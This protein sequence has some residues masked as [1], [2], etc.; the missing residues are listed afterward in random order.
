MK[1]L[2]KLL[3]AYLV[4]F[5]LITSAPLQG[6]VGLELPEWFS[7]EADAIDSGDF[8]YTVLSDGTAQITA[9]RGGESEVV[10]PETIDGIKVTEIG[11]NLF[12]NN[13][14]L[15]SI[16]LPSG[17]R[18]LGEGSFYNTSNLKE[19]YF[20]GDVASWCSMAIYPDSASPFVYGGGKLYIDGQFVENLVVPEGVT[21][22]GSR[23]F[24][25]YDHLKSVDFPSTLKSIEAFAFLHCDGLETL[26]IPDGVTTLGYGA[27]ELCGALKTVILG[28]GI[29]TIDSDVFY[30]SPSISNVYYSGVESQ[31]NKISFG[32]YNTTLTNAKRHYNYDIDSHTLDIPNDAISYDGN[33]YKAFEESLDW[34]EAKARCEEMGGHLMTVT[35]SEEQNIIADLLNNSPRDNYWLGATDT[36]VEG[37]WKWITGEPFEYTNWNAGEPNNRE[38]LEGEFENYLHVSP[39]IKFKWNDA[40]YDLDERVT[41]GVN[42]NTAGFICE[43]ENPHIYTDSC[44]ASERVIVDATCTTEGYTEIRCEC[45]YVGR[46]TIEKLPH[47]FI[48]WKN[49]YK[50]GNIVQFGSY[51]QS[52][53]KDGTLIAELNSL[54]PEWDNWTSYGYYSGNGKYGSMVQGDWMRYTD[55]EYKGNKYR[56]VKFTQYRPYST[57][58]ASSKS[59]SYQDENGY[60]I[61]TLYWFKFEPINWRVLDLNAGLVVSEYLLDTQAYSNTVYNNSNSTESKY[62]YFNDSNFTNYASD[63][64]TSS[65]RNWLNNDF[66][67]VAFTENQ[68]SEIKT[69]RIDNKGYFTLQGTA[70]YERLD[71]EAT[72]DKVFLLTSND[73]KTSKYGFS[74]SE[75]GSSTTREAQGSDYAKNQGL[76]TISGYNSS[77]WFLRTPGYNSNSCCLVNEIGY[78]YGNYNNVTQTDSGVRPALSLTDLAVTDSRYV[79]PS[80][81]ENGSITY[82]CKC[83]ATDVEVI[84]AT[85]HDFVDWTTIKE[86]TTVE[87]GKKE[88]TCTVCNVVGAEKIDRIKVDYSQDENYGIANFTILDATTKAPIKN[89][90]IFV[91][92]DAEGE[93]TFYTDENGKVSIVLPV[94]ENIITAYAKGLISR[95]LTIDIVH[96]ENEIPAI[97]LSSSPIVEAELVTTPMTK[98]EIE[99]AGIDITAPG[100]NNVVKYEVTFEFTAK[101]TSGDSSGSGTEEPKKETVTDTFYVNGNGDYFYQNN[102]T[103]EIFGETVTIH[104]TERFFLIITGDIIWL[105][106]MFHVQLYAYNNSNT[107]WIEDTVATLNLPEG[108]SLADMSEGVQTL[109]QQM[110]TILE[111]GQADCEWYVR[112]DKEGIYDL[113]ATL[114]GRIMPFNEDFSNE[115]TA[116][117]AIKVY[118]GKAFNI[119]FEVPS[120]THCGDEYPVK[121]ILKNVS[122]RP[123]YNVAHVLTGI[124]QTKVT[125]Y[126]NGEVVEEIYVKETLDKAKFV[127][128]FGPGDEIVLEVTAKILFESE[129]YKDCIFELVDIIFGAKELG[130]AINNNFGFPAEHDWGEWETVKEPTCGEAGEE[131]RVCKNS[132]A[133]IETREIETLPHDWDDGVINPVSTC[134]DHGIKT[135]ICKND[136]SHTKQENVPLDANNHIGETY[137]KDAKENS[138]EEDGYT[139]STHCLGC[140]VKFSDGEIIPAHRHDYHKIDEK[141]KAPDYG[142]AGYDYY[143]CS[144]DAS[145][146]YTVEISPLVK[147][148]FTA[149]FVTTAPFFKEDKIVAEVT[150]T[151]GDKFVAE[152]P[153]DKY[154][155]YTFAWDEYEL[156]DED[157]VIY[158][159]Y[160]EIEINDVTEPDAEKKVEYNNGVVNITLEAKSDSKNIKILSEKT[161]P[162]DVIL[163]LDQSGSMAETLSSNRKTK[164]D[165]LVECAN[166]FVYEIYENAVATGAQHRVAV[167]GFSY[168]DYN[169]GNYKNTGILAT[170]NGSSVNYK[171]LKSSHYASALI[172][173]V[174]ANGINANITKGINSVVADGATSAHLGLEMANNIF[175]V[176]AKEAD[177]E[178]IVLFI[179]DGTPTSWGEETDLV[180]TTAAKAITEAYELKNSHGAKVYSIGVHA[181][182]DPTANFT[183]DMYGVK[184][185][186][187]DTFK[188]YDFNRFLHAVSSNYK[189]AGSIVVSEMGEGSKS[190]GYYLGVQ[191]TSK[192]SEIFS[193]ILLSSVYEVKTFDKVTIVDTVSK[194]FTLTIEQETEMRERLIKELGIRNEDITVTRNDDGTTTLRFENVRAQKIYNDDGSSYYS[195]K[196]SF[197]VSADK[198]SLGLTEV[199]TNTEDAGVELDG[200]TIDKFTVPSVTL[201]PDRKLVV[202]TINGVVYRIEESKLGDNIVAPE[203]AL[204]EWN[205]P[206]GTVVD[207]DYIVFEANVVDSTEYT[208]TWISENS[209]ITE[210]YMFGEEIIIPKV[211]EKTYY[212][213]L[214]WS[215]SVP[216]TM[217]NYNITFTAIYTPKHT[218]EYNKTYSYGKCTEGIVTVYEC[219]CGDSYEE[220]AEA[221][222]HSA[223]AVVEQTNDGTLIEKVNCQVCGVTNSQQLT[224]K[225]TYR[226]GWWNT[227]VLDLTLLENDVSVQP[228]GTLEIRFYVGENINKNYTVYRIDENGNKTSYTPRKENGYLIFD[229]DHFSFYVVAE[230][231]EETGEVAENISYEEVYCISNGHSYES[232]VTAPTCDEIGYTTYTCSVCKDTYVTDEFSALGHKEE[233]IKGIEATC[234]ETGLS[235]I[236]KCSVCDKIFVEQTVIEA[237]GHTEE[238]IEGK[239]ATC[240]ETGLTD[241]VKCIVCDE[242]LVE[243]TVIEALGHTEEIVKGKDATCRNSGLTDGVKCSVCDKV[244]VAHERIPALGHNMGAYI[245]VKVPTCIEEGIE[246]SICSLCGNENSRTIAA[247]GHDYKDNVCTSCGKTKAE[248]CDHMCHKTGFMGFIWKIVRFFW[249]LFKMNPV[250][251]CGAKHY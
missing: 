120:I 168:S 32:R 76:Y 183:S 31:W 247:K 125:H 165:A 48:D 134:K 251:D 35:S 66:Y 122:D 180:K 202:F 161:K 55:V 169:G 86:P 18:R 187:R 156:K 196:V 173:V 152:P 215:P 73:V 133:H 154:D 213:F 77:F 148:T 100:N 232:V 70:G 151:Q 129:K 224:Y 237:L 97:G 44:K 12:Y 119:T 214:K 155:N 181:N 212:D 91:S 197:N 203:S 157:I 26:V 116:E 93:S 81:T 34:F 246:K 11:N 170:N 132:E 109:S 102:S 242:I 182:A 15:T 39:S 221:T 140:D 69:T 144:Y 218:H 199:N 121:I 219:A 23:V 195:A 160:T 206:E 101:E 158:G 5:M 37:E 107:D 211:A 191:D 17:I 117:E 210:T 241:I 82:S 130:D 145:H 239:V 3:A 85:G 217:P 188:S 208:V 92:T 9:Y 136:A 110:G 177:R 53:V 67:N 22:I 83:G 75:K 68:R 179:T 149:T 216:S 159:R 128:E 105:K 235:D 7:F 198:D 176:T 230:L 38:S 94:G 209:K 21:Y 19:I 147:T 14:T 118:S 201:E 42:L 150:F 111:G 71:G 57:T 245:V 138:C 41:G 25:A 29:T 8:S 184:T 95:T 228:D 172:P 13:K 6:F 238:I 10:V 186:N 200:E 72:D 135:Y 65:I 143:E 89:A 30:L 205:I 113:T 225:V 185:D 223:K 63:Y 60:N 84:E 243:Q 74:S 51:P 127:D 104:P 61:N 124:S 28:S 49:Q 90:S 106:E 193:K 139:G 54:A 163:V 234:S 36:E 50:V 62:A 189:E 146:Y 2:K 233:I 47:T 59:S 227:A 175:A 194:E 244:F 56:G 78:F 98:E 4:I 142:V 192:L 114:E 131:K 45:G 178:R 96:G 1:T 115:Y 231:D 79:L 220:T 112:G 190:S 58:S 141:C 46:K 204:A 207:G 123:I 236:V 137:I 248:N 222:K 226:D 27:F 174:A 33:Y 108:L 162:V 153:V 64:E 87:E 250:C 24:I 126:S 164:R 88:A 166:D 80:C 249:K 171:S 240:T 52:E 40:Y 103:H 229:A 20:E 167:V 43:W 16:T 99:D